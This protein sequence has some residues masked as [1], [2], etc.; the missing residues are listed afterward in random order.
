MDRSLQTDPRCEGCKSGLVFNPATPLGLDALKYVLDKVDMVLLMSVNP[1]FGGQSFIPATMDKLRQ[2]RK[3][4]DE[5][6]HEI[7]L[8]VDGGVK[9]DN[10]AE[11]KAAGADTFVSGSGI[12]G[13]GNDGDPNRYDSIIRLMR[14]SMAAVG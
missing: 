7:R 3:M 11:I 2:A 1:G 13:K 8:E 12:F 14:E 6:G 9:A 4:I 5:S 10:I